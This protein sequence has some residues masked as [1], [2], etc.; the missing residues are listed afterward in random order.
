MRAHSPRQLRRRL[1]AG[2]LLS[3]VLTIALLLNAAAA[4]AAG[5]PEAPV[6]G[7]ASA[8][9]A[10]TAVLAGTLNPAAKGEPGEWQFAYLQ[11][12]GKCEPGG[13]PAPAAPEHAAGEEKEAVTPTTVESLEPNAHY[14]FCLTES[15]PEGRAVGNVQKFTTLS[16]PPAV[17]AESA[18]AI[19]ATEATLEAQV[20]PNNR[21]TTVVFEYAIEE[22]MLGTLGASKVEVP[23][24]INGFGDQTVTA[25]TG[26]V[27]APGTFYFFRAVA[28]NAGGEETAGTPPVEFKTA[29]PPE[30]PQATTAE[31]SATTA[32]LHGVLNPGAPGNPGKYVFF[33]RPDTTG[34]CQ[35]E[36]EQS[37]TEA[38]AAGA[39]GEAAT[40]DAPKPE[41]PALLPNT[42]YAF[43][44]QATNGA[45]E[46]AIS[47]AQTFKTLAV[48]PTLSG[49][50]ARNVTAETA[51]LSGKLN[52]N[53]TDT[54]YLFEYG[55]STGYG[56]K[57]PEQD[58]GAGFTET[59][60][61][62][63]LTG[64]AKNKTYHWR[65]VATSTAGT[66]TGPDH[67]FIY[68]V[69][70]TAE[71]SCASLP[72][73][74]RARTEKIRVERNSTSLPDCRAYELV[75]PPNK[76]DSL[77]TLVFPGVGTS[78]SRAGDRVIAP[79]VQCFD[80]PA[81]CVGAR[82]NSGTPYAFERRLGGWSTHPL[83]L[84][85]MQFESTQPIS[86]GIEDG[87]A[88]YTAPLPGNTREGLY[89]TDTTGAFRL[90][91]PLG[92]N[93]T[94]RE[95]SA[96]IATAD[97]S[98][99][100]YQ[101]HNSVWP[102]FDGGGPAALLYEYVGSGNARPSLVAV[103]GEGPDSHD[104]IGVCKN[105]LLK[106]LEALAED[107]RTIYFEVERCPQGGT[108]INA[109]PEHAV[110]ARE[111][112]ARIDESHTVKISERAATGCEETSCTNSKPRDAEFQGASNTG[113]RAYF[114]STQKLID[115]ASEDES[116]DSA[117]NPGCYNTKAVGG[118]NLYESVC[119]S[120]CEHP[121]E[122]RLID[123]S[124][125]DSTGGGPR[126]QGVMAVP[127]DGSHVYFVAQ[128][129]L[130]TQANME[131]QKAQDG[132]DNLY[133]YD[134]AK[135]GQ[136]AFI[137]Q[138]GSPGSG[139][140]AMWRSG[141]GFANSTPE[142]RYLV[143]TSRQPLTKDV[144]DGEGPKR[145]YRYDSQTGQMTRV[146]VGQDGYN[147]NG[148]KAEA[149]I[150]SLG[151]GGGF[152]RTDP[153]MSDDGSL[154]FFESPGA[155]TSTAQEGNRNVYEWHSGQVAL[156]SDGR[157]TSGLVQ[158]LGASATGE[159]AFF[160]SADSLVGEDTDTQRDIYDAHVCSVAK[161]CVPAAAGAP[162]PCKG[163]GCYPS[164]PSSVGG[165]G[166]GTLAYSGPGDLSAAAV[167]GSSVKGPT[168]AQLRARR[169]ARALK[170]CRRL[171]GRARRSRCERAARRAFGARVAHHASSDRRAR[172]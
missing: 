121:A 110:P 101:T 8:I 66:T 39:Q 113:E 112:Y 99:I 107:G 56:T 5:P 40:G 61:T 68:P 63:H 166:G 97:L 128:G 100:V 118:C 137:A 160:T 47:T 34:E 41:G 28:V 33:Y 115:G 159:D 142:G 123:V 98:H 129:V 134:D 49:E 132:A 4:S 150:T 29:T 170:A 42:E 48:K 25:S 102:S 2:L 171:R 84:P 93:A 17:D 90:I 169:L 92:E 74:E 119:P 43:C 50:E 111:L 26:A 51:D 120:R 7:A 106:Y 37:T 1:P 10:T 62:A 157:D 133:V 149:E 13:T 23:G 96:M 18:S 82:G 151:S 27:L 73:P 21:E 85:A 141:I 153:T 86:A 103:S 148:Q 165:A 14:A 126:V 20:N 31:P 87:D 167:K 172:S 152:P 60:V 3:A 139:E 52:P 131:G 80:E 22:G 67:T 45:G 164:S 88:F 117:V 147:D 163:E 95:L 75:T 35:G 146:S 81:G 53:G 72:E 94:F 6:T 127:S 64:L 36:G 16:A 145:V 116:E 144:A 54:K 71:A 109:G 136:A 154:I 30:T 89:A 12:E 114:T 9:T 78:V 79:V 108:G 161:P 122:R 11:A 124:A 59:T 130:T 162:A 46:T 65:L 158:F 57:T 70:G 19:K 125:G 15:N 155:L 32:V 91:G 135:P 77:T 140:A 69:T 24:S 156:I 38:E 76:N 168:P 143:F 83:E 104:L 44:V 138:L 55:E 105:E 58:A